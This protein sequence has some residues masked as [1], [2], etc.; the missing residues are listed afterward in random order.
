MRAAGLP[1]SLERFGPGAL[2]VAWSTRPDAVLGALAML[3][4]F[5]SYALVFFVTGAANPV[6]AATRA[7]INVVPAGLL[8]V[9]T[10]RA[11]RTQV[12]T[13][14][15]AVQAALHPPLALAY[16]LAWYLGI[17]V[18]YGLQDGWLTQGL[19]P[20]TLSGIAFTW[21]MF[22]G[23]TLYAAIAGHAYASSFWRLAERLRHERDE[24]RAA[25]ASPRPRPRERLLLR[26]D[27]EI[28]PVDP[29][30][31]LR[32]SGAGDRTE[33]VTRTGRF[34]TSSTLAELEEALPEGFL[35]AHRSHLVA[36]AAILHAEPAGNGRLTLHLPGGDSVTASRAGSRAFRAAAL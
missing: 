11:L 8:A 10:A 3:L 16:A 25:A 2:R 36:L 33:V 30:D 14:S 12:V 9:P 7:L 24:A 4:L 1:L 32:I 29:G 20:R 15:L 18:L 13:K 5:G 23:V 6:G 26:Q 28:V 27:R 21:Q 35:R 17:Q 31:I 22:Q 19:Q 34:M